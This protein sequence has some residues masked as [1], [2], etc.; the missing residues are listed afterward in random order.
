MALLLDEINGSSY[1]LF[2]L[3]VSCLKHLL[4]VNVRNGQAWG[5]RRSCGTASVVSPMFVS[6]N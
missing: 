1:L 6:V 3:D 5:G 2:L 4:F